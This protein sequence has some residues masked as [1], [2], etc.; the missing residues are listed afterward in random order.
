MDLP[1]LYSANSKRFKASEIRELLEIS[2]RP[3]VIS[4]AGGLPNTHAFPVDEVKKIANIVLEEEGPRA[5]QYGP[6]SGLREFRE[7]IAE[8]VQKDGIHAGHRNP[9]PILY[10]PVRPPPN[11][12]SGTKSRQLAA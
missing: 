7:K 6:T 4:F 5:L 8:M 1:R 3:G 9:K 11:V 2:Q 10:E 12:R